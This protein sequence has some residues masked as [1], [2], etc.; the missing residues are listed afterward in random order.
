MPATASTLHRPSPLRLVLLHARADQHHAFALQHALK[1][2]PCAPDLRLIPVHRQGS[3]LGIAAAMTELALAKAD[4]VVFLLSPRYFVEHPDWAHQLLLARRAQALHVI[5]AEP[6]ELRG[7]GFETY[8]VEL[9]SNTVPGVSWPRML[10]LASE[11]GERLFPPQPIRDVLC[12][13]ASPDGLDR[14]ALDREWRAIDEVNRRGGKPLDLDVRWATRVHDVQDVL[15]ERPHE[16]LHFSAHGEPGSL[17]FEAHDGQPECVDTLALVHMLAKH[18]PRALIFNACH[19]ADTL[20][21]AREFVPHII[22]MQGPT[23]DASA[24]EFSRAFYA[25]LA[26]GR[27]VAAAFEHAFDSLSLSRVHEDCRPRLL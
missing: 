4:V 11:L 16:L 15:L 25:A 10:R 24:I 1:M 2:Q 6:S 26:H 5:V 14:L 13:F 7:T 19:T 8:A 20:A 17:Y 18:Q 27:T 3:S 12:M 22:A 23:P 9:P 21:D